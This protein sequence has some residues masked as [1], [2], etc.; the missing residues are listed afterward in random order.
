[1]VRIFRWTNGKFHGKFPVALALFSFTWH[2]YLHRFVYKQGESMKLFYVF[3]FLMVAF[4]SVANIALA[5]TPFH[6]Y[7]ETRFKAIENNIDADEALNVI[8]SQQFNIKPTAAIYASGSQV[9]L[10]TLPAN[11]VIVKDFMYIQTALVS[12]SSN[13]LAVQCES[14]NDIFTATNLAVEASGTM[15]N[16]A[17][18]FPNTATK[19]VVQTGSNGCSVKAVVGSGTTGITA[20]EVELIIEYVLY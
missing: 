6:P 12:A 16:G 19:T 9:T 7:E 3:V 17:Q 2:N 11:A 15:I 4:F 14:A 10:G 5:E 18:N 20:G 13:T 1:M 8:Y